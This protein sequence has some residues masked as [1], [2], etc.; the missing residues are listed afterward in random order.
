MT[1]TSQAASQA[2]GSSLFT[3]SAP[4]GAGKSS[5]IAALLKTDPALSL[6]VSHTTRQPRPG[7]QNGREYHFVTTDDF[8][9]RLEEGEF[10][11]HALVHGNYY[12]TSKL[13]VL[14]QLQAGSD[15]LLEI[16]WQGALQIREL[17]P[18]T[19]SIFILPPSIAVLEERLNK[20]GQ[21]SQEIIKQ[22]IQG[23]ALEI[24][25]ASDFD[26]VIINNDFNLALKQLASVIDAARCRTQKQ[27]LKNNVL[28]AQFGITGKN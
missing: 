6:S 25:H 3:V 9:K 16:D 21:D 26:Y 11:E 2:T 19:V 15:V 10:L 20:R 24:S 13:K 18:D 8:Q 27:S 14:E 22:R 28:F 4:S 1:K 23:A 17:F 12:G 7:E 5:L